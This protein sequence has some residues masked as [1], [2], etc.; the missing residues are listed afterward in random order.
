MK[1]KNNLDIYNF[2]LIFSNSKLSEQESYE[3]AAKANHSEDEIRGFVYELCLSFLA[4]FNKVSTRMY[5][6]STY[7]KALPFLNLDFLQK[8]DY[9]Y[10][11]EEGI[12][13][14]IE[15]LKFFKHYWCFFNNHL[16]SERLLSNKHETISNLEYMIPNTLRN[17]DSLK[18]LQAFFKDLEKLEMWSHMGSELMDSHLEQI[19]YQGHFPLLYKYV[20]GVHTIFYVDNKIKNINQKS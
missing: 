20:K 12:S 3:I 2:N 14:K 9:T 5:F 8:F 17:D 16:I 18:L 13:V 11:F 4:L 15:I 7:Q 6:N 10:N 1:A 19:F